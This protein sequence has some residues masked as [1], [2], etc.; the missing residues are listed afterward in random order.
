VNRLILIFG[1]FTLAFIQY[2]L[3]N[4]DFAMDLFYPKEYMKYS[5][6]ERIN[7]KIGLII[8]NSFIIYIFL[9][10]ISSIAKCCDV[11]EHNV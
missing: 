2:V 10:I 7:Q 11:K 6:E 8:F 9:N 4:F 3:G 1:I 5:F